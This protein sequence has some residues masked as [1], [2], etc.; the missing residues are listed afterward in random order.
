M[1]VEWR[2]VGTE[3]DTRRARQRCHVDQ[4]CRFFLVG[5]R[6]RVGKNQS[7]FGIGIADFDG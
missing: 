7:A 6:K 2:Q 1:R 4:E 3:R 5:K